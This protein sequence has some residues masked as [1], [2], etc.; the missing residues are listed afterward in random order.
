MKISAFM[1]ITNPEK[2]GDTYLEAIITHLYWADELVVIDGGS[3]DGSIEKIKALDDRRIRIVTRP[4]PQDWSWIEFARAWNRGLA[5]CTGDW[6]AAGESD[7]IFHENEA[8]RVREE[9][10]R[11]TAKGKAVM[12]IQKLQSAS[13][14][15][16]MSKS[17]MYYFV[18]KAKY[19]Q[20]RYGF[21]PNHETD[22]AHPIWWE[23]SV[24]KENNEEIPAG[25][26]IVEGSKYESLIG[27]TGANIYNYLWT[28]K[29]VEQVVQERIKAAAGWNKFSGFTGVYK[30]RFPEGEEKIREWVKGQLMSV[31]LK[32]T[33]TIRLEDQPQVMQEKIARDLKPGMIGRKELEL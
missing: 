17:Q 3:T 28:F 1:P 23:G 12:K 21:D 13:Y 6:V 2:R 33:R 26:A 20:I 9:I 16:W 24:Y 10:E 27:G 30:R 25:V 7:H 4:W 5:E 18:Y 31:R 29:T 22:L 15:N 14:E 19:P 32:A 11:E 8:A